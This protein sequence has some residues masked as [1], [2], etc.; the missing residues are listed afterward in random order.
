MTDLAQSAV[1]DNLVDKEIKRGLTKEALDNLKNLPKDKIHDEDEHNKRIQDVQSKLD[2]L[3][4][5]IKQ[6]P[7]EKMKLEEQLEKAKALKPPP[8][9]HWESLQQ[10]HLLASTQRNPQWAVLQTDTAERKLGL[11]ENRNTTGQNWKIPMQLTFHNQP[12]CN[13]AAQKLQQPT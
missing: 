11:V 7:E 9:P 10:Q 6:K 2:D 13:Q 4:K 8:M 5:T 12:R 3:E 1:E